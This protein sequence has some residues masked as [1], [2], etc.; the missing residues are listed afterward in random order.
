MFRLQYLVDYQTHVNRTDRDR[1]PYG[2][3]DTIERVEFTGGVDSDV[4]AERRHHQYTDDDFSDRQIR[5]TQYAL[6]RL[7]S[8]H[9]LWNP[10]HYTAEIMSGYYGEEVREVQHTYE[11][12]IDRRMEEC[13]GEIRDDNIREMLF[14]LLEYEYGYVLEDIKYATL[15]EERVALSDVY[16]PND[17]YVGKISPSDYAVSTDYPIGVYKDRSVIDGYNRLV[18]LRSEES[19]DE[20]IYIYNFK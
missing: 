5:A 14:L 9:E 7:A 16:T 2:R 19:E 17:R 15:E 6:S 20:S 12:K 3:G 8:I 1:D 4:V 13:M 18:K 11:D 10:S